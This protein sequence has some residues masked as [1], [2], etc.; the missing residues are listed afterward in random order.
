MTDNLNFLNSYLAE[1]KTIV[2]KALDQYLPGEDHFPEI[3]FQSVRYS[4]FAGG[5]R[6][7]PILCLAAAEAVGGNPSA[8][9]PVACALEMIHT[10]SLIHDDLP[11]MDDDDYRRGR[12]T[13][14]RV[15]GEDIAVLAG[16][17][18]LTEAFHLLS[19]EDAA[20]K[21]PPERLLQAIR[22]IS[23][24]AGLFGMVGGQ[25]ADIQSEGKSADRQTLEYI[26]LHK[27]GEM[28]KVSVVAGAL[29]AGAEEKNVEALAGFGKN[30]GLAFQITDDILD[31]EGDKDALGKATGQD[32]ALKKM[33]YPALMGL[34]QAK[35]KAQQYL[36]AALKDLENFDGRAEPLRLIA[37]FIV[38]RTV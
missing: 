7:R 24:S 8:L 27:T 18:L 34:D 10:Y 16:D 20:G 14:H 22:E 3:I 2:D 37:K 17:A 15:F 23:W 9:L 6:L 32:A 35:E 28:I 12:L 13:N 31:I 30:I 26:H 11:V 21:F 4:V 38:E 1:K 33:T 29:L 36:G 5:K 25:V 19:G